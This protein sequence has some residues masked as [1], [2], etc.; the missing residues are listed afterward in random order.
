MKLFIVAPFCGVTAD[1]DNVTRGIDFPCTIA[2]L[3]PVIFTVAVF[4]SRYV[5]LPLNTGSAFLT[6]I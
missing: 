3:L 2:W 4:V 1:A 5:M 6:I